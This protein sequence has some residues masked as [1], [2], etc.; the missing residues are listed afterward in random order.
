MARKMTNLNCS[1]V[2]QD[3][4]NIINKLFSIISFGSTI[5]VTNG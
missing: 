4:S 2:A 1:E 3:K 5:I